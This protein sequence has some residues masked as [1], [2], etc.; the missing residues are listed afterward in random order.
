MSVV[1]LTGCDS[2]DCSINNT[3]SLTIGFYDG[4]GKKV[5][6]VDT[7]SVTAIGTDSVLFN[8]AVNRH[9]VSVPM[10]YYK[11]CDTLVLTVWGKNEL[12]DDYLLRDTLK[13]WKTNVENF[14]SLDCPVNM[15]HTIIKADATDHFIDRV[16]I[17]LPKVEYGEDENIMVFLRTAE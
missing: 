12:G 8:R 16:A 10:S 4:D 1:L 9:D 3:V 13:V 17:A 7:L 11:N 5:Q 2:F 6:L 15:Y 14:E